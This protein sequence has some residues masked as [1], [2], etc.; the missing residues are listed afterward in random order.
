MICGKVLKFIVVSAVLM[1]PVF[2]S[3]AGDALEA[4]FSSLEDAIRSK[5]N[6]KTLTI[7]QKAAGKKSSIALYMMAKI[8]F[9]GAYGKTADRKDA[10]QYL[11][12]A[13][14]AGFRPAIVELARRE[15]DGRTPKDKQNERG[16]L[17]LCKDAKILHAFAV[18]LERL[19][20]KEQKKL[21]KDKTNEMAVV[22]AYC[23]LRGR[24][25]EGD[26]AE[27]VKS[28]EKLLK[29]S[30]GKQDNGEAHYIL[31]RC[32]SDGI[33]VEPDAET[34]TQHMQKALDS[35]CPQALYYV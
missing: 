26:P 34:A 25:V 22:Q 4:D 5:D 10:F 21:L 19:E 12:K 31:A 28:L 14:K 27:A 13:A 11:E 33:G 20:A 16:A 15:F 35:G 32:Y 18:M 30:I 23:I 3:A 8:Y 2:L 17:K 9:N 29:R 6:K 1:C 24:S 7:I